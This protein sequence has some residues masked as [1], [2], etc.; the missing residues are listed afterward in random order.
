[1]PK[2]M[3]KKPVQPVKPVEPTPPSTPAATPPS[4]NLPV[5]YDKLEM[6]EYSTTNPR[7]PLTI[8][9]MKAYMGWETEKQFKERKCVEVPGSKPEM[10]FF[11]DQFHCLNVAG[12]KVRTNNNAHNRPFDLEWC[13]ELIHTVLEGQ[14]AGPHTIPGETVNGETIRVSKYGRVLSGQHQMTAGIL[15]GEWLH[16]TRDAGADTPDN[17]KY[18]AWRK[19]GN[20]F[21]ETIVIRGM[22]EDPRVLMSI[23]YVKPR[24]AADVFYTSEV[25]KNCTSPERKELCRMLA[26]AVDV[27][28]TRTDT[29]GYRT[30]PEIV[31]FLDRHKK[32]LDCVLHLFEENSA[33]GGKKISRL[34]LQPGVCAGLTY[35]MASS[36]EKTDGDVY[37]NESPPTEKNLDWS[38]WDKATEF[39]V[40]LTG[41]KDFLPVRTALGRLYDSTVDN[42]DNQGLGGRGPEKLA[43]LAKAWEVWLHTT[44]GVTFTDDDLGPEG[45]LCLSYSDLDD[46]GKKLP[47]GE[48]KLLDIADFYGIDCPEVKKS[49]GKGAGVSKA[50]E[51]PP[52]TPEEM[53][54]MYEDADERRRKQNQPTAATK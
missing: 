13:K 9:K 34:R 41:A 45:A 42:E 51:P 28:W 47:N 33:K 31:A 50:P 46:T 48:I 10:W 19:E 23:D 8:E 6:V 1:M 20:P 54:K 4:P 3:K 32:L 36:G 7:G 24:T 53:K 15:A 29:R 37:R 14:W 21:L 22:S 11:G 52:P 43:I 38:N 25:F 27:L 18:P 12:E 49:G 39:W 2:T 40:M 35:I 30:H 44:G 17:P 5:V 16:K 26:S